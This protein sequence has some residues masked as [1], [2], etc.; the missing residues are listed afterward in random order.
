V[1]IIALFT[2]SNMGKNS[3][4]IIIAVVL[5]L[6][7]GLS[8]DQAKNAASGESASTSLFG[9]YSESGSSIGGE[10]VTDEDIVE[11]IGKTSEAISKVQADF[12]EEAEKKNRSIYYGK[13]LLSYPAYLNDPDPSM[14]YISITTYLNRGEKVNITGW[15]LKSDRSGNNATIGKA[16]VLPYPYV[17]GKDDVILSSGD[18]AYI[19]K[20]F[21]PINTS[22]RTNKCTGYFNENRTFYP[23]L[24]RECPLPRDE[25]ENEVLPQFSSVLD[26]D[27]ECKDLINGLQRCSVPTGLSRLPDTVTSSCKTFMQT[28]VN[29]NAC[30]ANHLGDTDFRGNEWFIY[31]ERFGPLW[32][33]KRETIKL[34]DRLGLLVHE[35]SYG[36]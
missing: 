33:D 36:Y 4:G 14:E 10:P 26:R 34:Y 3:D 35:I 16:S 5:F 22:F 23:Y 6:I 19:V 21:S 9:E 12:E 25:L 24:A 8:W 1:L 28:Q 11:Q 29:Y 30:V 20:G 32:R 27:D 31:L 13:V 2:R 17:K 7:V 18:R 15:V